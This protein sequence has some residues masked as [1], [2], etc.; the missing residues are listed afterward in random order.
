MSCYP[1]ISIYRYIDIWTAL[2]WSIFLSWVGVRRHTDIL[3]DGYMNIHISDIRCMP[4]FFCW[5]MFLQRTQ[6]QNSRLRFSSLRILWLHKGTSRF[7]TFPYGFG[8]AVE[9]LCGDYPS[10][11]PLATHRFFGT[12]TGACQP[13]FCHAAFICHRQCTMPRIATSSDAAHNSI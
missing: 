2:F 12:G 4:P 13:Q 8:R 9:P 10:T 11:T 3:I 5:S 6:P 7:D 1:Y